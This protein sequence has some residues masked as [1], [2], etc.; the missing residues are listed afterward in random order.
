MPED[1]IVR[2]IRVEYK[3]AAM[4]GDVLIPHV[5]LGEEECV[6]ALCGEDGVIY[7]VVAFLTE[8]KTDA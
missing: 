5:T 6:V 3:K 4:Q 1:D 8:R 7:A 2:E